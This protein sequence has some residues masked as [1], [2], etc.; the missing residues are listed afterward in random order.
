MFGYHRIYK[1]GLAVFLLSSLF[2]SPSDLL[3]MFTLARIAQGF[4]SA[5]LMSVYTALV[6]LICTFVI[7]LPRA[8]MNA[9]TFGLLI[10]SLSG[11][12]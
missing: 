12:A 9:L 6:H 11:F 1:C 8:V 10:T 5:A 7:D 3:Q 4:S 2:C